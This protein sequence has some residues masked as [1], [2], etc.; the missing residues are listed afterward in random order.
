M[1]LS[2]EFGMH[3]CEIASITV[4]PTV[5]V[6][7]TIKPDNC[8]DY[9]MLYIHVVDILTGTITSCF[10]KY[11]ILTHAHPHTPT[12]SHGWT[13]NTPFSAGLSRG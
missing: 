3:V 11:S 5:C 12:N 2:T 1:L 7:S 8:Y 9:C 4:M 10:F 13:T 6:Y